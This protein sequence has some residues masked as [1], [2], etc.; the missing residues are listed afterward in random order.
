M[1]DRLTV[2]I[3]AAGKGTRMRSSLPKVLHPVC[4]KPMVQWVIDA[5]RTAGADRI[6]AITRPGDGVAEG[7]PEDVG[8]AEQREG[9]GT[10]AAVLAARDAVD[11]GTVVVLSG[12]VPLQSAELIGQLVAT[13]REQGAAA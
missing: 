5:A 1:S 13:H 12:D 11:G 8:V 3:M 7:L 10:G 4:G 2:L 9:E 6:V